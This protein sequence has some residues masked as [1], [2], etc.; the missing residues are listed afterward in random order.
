MITL[1]QVSLLESRVS[2]VI[3]T[4]KALRAENAGLQAENR[5]LQQ[6]LVGYE[7]RVTEL[8]RLV[9]QFKEDQG[10]IEATILSALARLNQFEDVLEAELSKTVS[11][12]EKK[13]EGGVGISSKEPSIPRDERKGVSPSFTSPVPETVERPY[14]SPKLSNNDTEKEPHPIDEIDAA[15]AAQEQAALEATQQ[16]SSSFSSNELDIF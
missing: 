14:S 12:V 4:L 15:L 13:E 10:K 9:Q 3:E 2:K 1:E 6:Q 5:R 8:E 16:K 11:P 7:K